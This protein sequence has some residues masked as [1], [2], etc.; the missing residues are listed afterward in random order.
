MDLPKKQEMVA[1][2]SDSTGFGS[3]GVSPVITVGAPVGQTSCNTTD[4]GES[5]L[6]ILRDHMSNRWSSRRC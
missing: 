3:G 2:M 1:V 5:S 4:P 6:A